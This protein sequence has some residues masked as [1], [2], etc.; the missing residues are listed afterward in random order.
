MTSTRQAP[1]QHSGIF[2]GALEDVVSKTKYWWLFL[3]TGIAWIVLGIFILRFNA[4]TVAAVAIL[5]GAYCLVAAG[6][7]MVT[8]SVS[9][10][11][12]RVFRWLLAALFVVVAILAF[13]NPGGTF[14][15]L[16]FL[17]SFYFVFR[18]VYDIAASFAASIIPGWWALL[19]TGLAEIALG[20]WAAS[21]W[22]VSVIALVVLVAAG[23]I[24][25]G[26]GQIASAFLIRKAG[27]ETAALVDRRP[28]G[29]SRAA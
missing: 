4:T 14:A 8:A 25:Y 16:A 5:F 23:A 2:S 7:E 6:N 13:Y 22:K 11:G 24:L 29:V 19:I 27:Q 15:S 1:V 26:V 3:V 28:T 10:S 17:M 21:S 9:S 20:F 18:G 12:W